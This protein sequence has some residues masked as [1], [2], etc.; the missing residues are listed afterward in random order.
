MPDRSQRAE[1]GTNPAALKIVKNDFSSF[2][3]SFVHR[4]W[5]FPELN[6]PARPAAARPESRDTGGSAVRPEP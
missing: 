2:F 6:E 1:R 3:V 4:S 5:F